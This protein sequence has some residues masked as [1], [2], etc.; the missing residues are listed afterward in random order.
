MSISPLL[1]ALGLS[2]LLLGN[3]TEL[4]CQAMKGDKEVLAFLGMA[5]PLA[6]ED[7]GTGV[8][9]TSPQPPLSTVFW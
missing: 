4:V 9:T 8:L 2:G 1:V 3:G 7:E 6:V 5:N